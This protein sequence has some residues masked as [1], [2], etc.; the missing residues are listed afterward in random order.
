MD[1]IYTY[2]YIYG[3]IIGRA[4]GPW[5]VRPSNNCPS[6]VFLFTSTRARG[7]P[8]DLLAKNGTLGDPAKRQNRALGA[9]WSFFIISGRFW[10]IEKTCFFRQGPKSII[11]APGWRRPRRAGV[12]LWR[13][14]YLSHTLPLHL[15]Y[16]AE[17]LMCSVLYM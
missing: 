14:P 3:I 12:R 1:N 9:F 7:G 16:L 17:H 11:S 6:V 10:P 13:V 15:P 8:W 4:N 2:I 5:R